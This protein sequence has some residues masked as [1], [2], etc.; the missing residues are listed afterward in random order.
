MRVGSLVAGVITLAIG[1]FVIYETSVASGLF[2]FSSAIV[3]G[4]NG[5]LIF[6]VALALLGLVLTARGFTTPP[7]KLSIK[8][9][10]ELGVVGGGQQKVEASGSQKAA[11]TPLALQVLTE[12]S[13]GQDPVQVAL[14][15]KMDPSAIS[16]KMADLRKFGYLSD[17]NKLTEKGFEAL[18]RYKG[19]TK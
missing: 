16:D 7:T 2:N 11:L 13:K 3:E 6:G 8:E 14:D 9:M 17:A 5:F 12:I 4:I 19:Y 15:N 18:N 10:K 1:L